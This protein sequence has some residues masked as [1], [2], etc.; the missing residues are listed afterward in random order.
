M[1]TTFHHAL[2]PGLVALAALVP[3]TCAPG[4]GESLTFSAVDEFSTVNT[5]SATWSYRAREGSRTRDGQY[6]LLPSFSAPQDPW[7][8]HP[9]WNNGRFHA[10]AIGANRTGG[11]LW[12][13]GNVGVPGA[14]EWPDGTLWLNPMAPGL[15]VVSW[16]SP[17][18]L[19]V[20]IAFTFASI[21]ANNQEGVL[22]FVERNDGADTL[23]AGALR[24]AQTTGLVRLPDVAVNAG[25]RINFV[26]DANVTASFDSTTL[27][28]TITTAEHLPTALPEPGSVLALGAG[29][30]GIAVTAGTLRRRTQSGGPR[31]LPRYRGRSAGS[32]RPP[33]GPR[34]SA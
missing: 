8:G 18:T 29:L 2:R 31:R 34:S 16:L 5:A 15:T 25:D 19:D 14:V 22:W 9:F 30:V 27:V 28:A 23:A 24:T 32:C 11:S 1:A 21:D 17:A 13:F 7:Q 20:E 12:L 33:L 6:P 26:L 4:S 10:P 3:L